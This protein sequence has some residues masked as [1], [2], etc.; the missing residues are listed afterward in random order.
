MKFGKIKYETDR[1]IVLDK[2][3]GV[4]ST[5]ISP[6]IVHRLDRGT[7]GLL[8]VAKGEIEKK[9]LEEEFKKRRVKKIYLCLV[10]GKFRQKKGEIRGYIVRERKD[11][12]KRKFVQG[13]GESV[14]EK[15]KR[16]AV[17][18]Y[19]VLKKYYCKIFEKQEEKEFN[20]STLLQIEILTGRTHQI[21]AQ[22]A[23][24]HH[25]VIG[26]DL[27]GGKKMRQV[28]QKLG[29]ER[30]FL[31]AAKLSF[32]DPWEK[33]RVKIVSNLPDDLNRVLNKLD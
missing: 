30:Q 8:L 13:R 1:Y 2:V 31:H 12:R 26:D 18:K 6:W 4:L 27:Y 33:K 20:Y 22:M 15:H 11:Y 17:S 23:T 21:R 16:L 3:A 5:D 24:I 28:N 32:F 10:T 19:K 29:L 25:P 7:S 14:R 9:R